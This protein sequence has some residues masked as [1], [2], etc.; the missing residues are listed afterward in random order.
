MHRSRRV[1]QS[2]DYNT[3]HETG[4]RVVRDQ[5]FVEPDQDIVNIS[6][7]L[8]SFT[9][10]DDM[11]E[12]EALKTDILVVDEEIRDIIDESPLD[13][14]SVDEVNEAIIK[15]EQKRSEFRRM[16]IQLRSQKPDD[17]DAHYDKPCTETLKLIK[18]YIKAAKDKKSKMMARK[19]ML[20]NDEMQ[21]KE[22]SI[23][24]LIED[25]RRCIEELHKDCSRCVKDALDTDLLQWKSETTNI[26]RSF[27]RNAEKYQQILSSPITDADMLSLI[28]IIGERYDKLITLKSSYLTSLSSEISEREIDKQKLFDESRLNIKLAKF[29][30]YDSQHDVYTFQSEFEKLFLRTTPRRVLPDLLKNNYLADPALTLVKS[31]N[32]IKEIWSRLHFAYG[33]TKV[34][35]AKK[36]QQISKTDSLAKLKDPEKLVLGLGKLTNVLRDVMT[37]ARQNNIEANLFYSDGLE[38][39]YRLLGDSRVTR[40]LSTTCDEEMT[41]KD[42]WKKLISF[43]DKEQ[44]LQ[45]Q[46]MMIH[47]GWK[48]DSKADIHPK[49]DNHPKDNRNT[50]Y[51]GS[52]YTNPIPTNI[53]CSICGSPEGS[54]EHVSTQGPGGSRIIQYYTCKKFVELTPLGRLSLLKEKGYCFQCLFPGAAS[55][56]GKHKEGKCQHDYVCPHAAHQRYQVK[57]HILCC[58]EHKDSQE[59]QDLLEKYRQNV[60]EVHIF[61]NFQR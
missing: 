22:R 27:E 7:Q 11:S 13:G 33:D 19:S 54:S 10:H 16:V 17:Y 20:K 3:L 50:R 42:T 43:L 48:G 21:R 53:S 34:M 61:Q 58:D 49:A 32:D 4:E 15:L 59:N 12:L 38:R 23:M 1:L 28:N 29:C 2:I 18:T 44:K 35:L 14:V 24:F 45:Q 30:G 47:Q 57:K 46:K 39:V 5:E 37:L 31:L 8:E 55:G 36:L 25:T 60:S 51:R 26:T 56:S 41:P 6:N 52:F 9:L 40:W